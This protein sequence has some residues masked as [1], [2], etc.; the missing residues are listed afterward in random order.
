[1]VYVRDT[2]GI[3]EAPL[4]DVWSF[5]GSGDS[6]SS[7]HDHQSVQRARHSENSG[8][9]SWDQSFDGV[10]VR[11]SM[12]WTSYWPLGIAY[13]VLDGPFLGSKFFLIY[14]P[15]GRTTAV[16]VFGEFTSPTLPSSEVEP[17]VKRFFHK[18]F[19]QDTEALRRWTRKTSPESKPRG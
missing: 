4:E 8:T 15:R 11:F 18:E 2:D 16:H 7:S 17:A 10:N 6:H 1:M 14:E 12:R 13:D 3:F 9:Y 19:Q 5:V